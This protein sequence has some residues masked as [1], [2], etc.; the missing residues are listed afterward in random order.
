MTQEKRSE[1]E[2][3]WKL[4]EY[5]TGNTGVSMVTVVKSP[6]LQE[7]VNITGKK[8]CRGNRIQQMDG[9]QE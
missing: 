8:P 7:V 2:T 3:T 5:F 4:L 1:P 6:E 9:A